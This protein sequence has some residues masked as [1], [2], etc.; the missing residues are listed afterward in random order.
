MHPFVHE[1]LGSSNL[2]R[3]ESITQEGSSRRYSR[4]FTND[5]SFVVCESNH[6]AENKSFIAFADYFHQH[7]V[8]VPKV[9]AVSADQCCYI[10]E[11]LGP[12][13]LLDMRLKNGLS[14]EV[15]VLYQKALQSLAFMQTRA[16]EQFDYSW[17]FAASSFDVQ[18][19]LA[20]LN[21]FKYYFLDIHEIP[22][23]R[24]QLQQEFHELAVRISTLPALGFMFRDFQARNILIH[25]G[26]PFFIDFQGGM[27]GPLAY[28][29]ASLLWQAKAELPDNWKKELYQGYKSEIRN[30]IPLDDHL[31]DEVYNSIILLRLLQVLGAYGFRGL[32]QK[33][34]HFISSI[35]Q[36]LGN[37]RSYLQTHPL[38]GMPELEKVLAQLGQDEM[39]QRYATKTETSSTRLKVRIR[40]FSYKKGIPDDET[41]NGG[42]FVFDCRGIL[43]PGRYAEYKMKTGRDQEVIDFLEDKT[44]IA[45]FLEGVYQTID[46]SVEDYIARGFENLLISFGCT[47]GQHRSV[48]CADATAKHLSKKYGLQVDVFH[49]EQEARA[50][51]YDENISGEHL[52]IT[53]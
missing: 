39:L 37:L 21:Y 50:W 40:S 2:I 27:K 5:Q 38:H 16:A 44:R 6:V 30:F 52:K 22:Y 19:V 47:G 41:G 10:L 32:I 18:A 43:N 17:C 34:N 9:M 11:D 53:Q 14:Q 8:P 1:F 42:G 48:Y 45:E 4:V 12:V 7:G 15:F 36:G 24:M 29:A 23:S 31:F 35:P 51:R 3:S 46:I 28:D 33:K 49:R 13:S 25:D 26:Q 20:D